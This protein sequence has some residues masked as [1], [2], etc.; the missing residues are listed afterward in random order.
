MTILAK[1][2]LLN[3]FLNVWSYPA[4]EET[5]MDIRTVI[6]ISTK[7][8]MFLPEFVRLSVC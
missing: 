6:F 4:D 1:K 2:N 7:E 5:I 3:L 8:V